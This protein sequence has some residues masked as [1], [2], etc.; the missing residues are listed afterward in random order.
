MPPF[1]LE[2]FFGLS[3]RS[4]SPV[5]IIQE[6]CPSKTG[7]ADDPL[8]SKL[9]QCSRKA[10]FLCRSLDSETLSIVQMACKT[11]L[12]LNVPIM[13][14]QASQL[15]E[16]NHFQFTPC[17]LD[18]F[19]RYLNRIE[20][21]SKSSPELSDMLK[22][23]CE[24]DGLSP[25][26]AISPWNINSSLAFL[27]ELGSSK[28]T[29]C[30]SPAFPLFVSVHPLAERLASDF[31]SDAVSRFQKYSVTIECLLKTEHFCQQSEK[32]GLARIKVTVQPDASNDDAR[33]LCQIPEVRV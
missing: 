13:L 27:L 8:L 4:D 6:I 12:T 15:V 17:L 26:F 2:D 24:R 7:P 11:S 19:E 23:T 21:V 28:S 32:S 33:S 29:Q 10:E 14:F 9:I 18:N 31:Q 16:E 5:E 3:I 25:K 30:S 20:S 1:L 22:K